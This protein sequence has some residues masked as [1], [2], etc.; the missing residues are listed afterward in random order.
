MALSVGQI[1]KHED[2]LW[3]VGLVNDSRARLDP[4]SGNLHQL[5]TATFTTYGGSVNVSPD[6]FLPIMDEEA[7]SNDQQRRVNT[8]RNRQQ[9]DSRE[10]RVVMAN[11]TQVA[12]QPAKT[13]GGPVQPKVGSTVQAN[14][15]RL[16]Q[17]K[18]K[19]ETTAAEGK[20]ASQPSGASG[21]GKK[22]AGAAGAS[23][24][25][26][27]KE[28]VLH[29]CKCGCTDEAGK[30]TMVA[31]HF[32][33]GH[34]ARFKGWLLQVERGKM[35]VKDLPPVVQ[36][37][38]QWVKKGEGYVPTTNYKGEPHSGYEKAKAE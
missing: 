5:L 19:K 2:K 37:A 3:R 15:D 7:L 24:P 4:I 33:M 32:A 8:L 29:A 28:K 9:P 36:K 26:E 11:G 27:K 18:A 12:T 31:G 30:P 22:A 16:A 13:A 14:K 34:D 1:V 38:Y 35:A 25:R 10:E 20:V 17:I 23:V 21:G 6:S